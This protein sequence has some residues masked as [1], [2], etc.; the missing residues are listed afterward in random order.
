MGRAIGDYTEYVGDSASTA[1]AAVCSGAC[2]G[3]RHCCIRRGSTSCKGKGTFWG[4]LFPIFTMGNAIGSPTVKCFRFVC[5]NL[6]HFFSAKVSLE[7]SIRG[8]FGDIFSFE[9]KVGVYEK[10]T[11]KL[12]L[13]Y[14]NIRCATCSDICF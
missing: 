2:V 8:L 11:K 12:Q 3:P 1:G 10:L 5:E 7:S 4:F 9:I 14:E 6:Q 13:F